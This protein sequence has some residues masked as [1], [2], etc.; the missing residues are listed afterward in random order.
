MEKKQIFANTKKKKRI[1][2]ELKTMLENIL[3][4]LLGSK[5]RTWSVWCI[6]KVPMPTLYWN[7]IMDVMQVVYIMYGPYRQIGSHEDFSLTD[8]SLLI[9]INYTVQELYSRQARTIYLPYT[10]PTF[11]LLIGCTKGCSN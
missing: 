3:C 6:S 2:M 10:N 7:L 4:C 9:P 8:D 11:L 5:T 1:V